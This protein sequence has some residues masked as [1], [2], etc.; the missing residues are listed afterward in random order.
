MSGHR[1]IVTVRESKSSVCSLSAGVHFAVRGHH[2]EGLGTPS[3]ADRLE[4]GQGLTEDRKLD[5][6]TLQTAKLVFVVKA[7][8]EHLRAVGLKNYKEMEIK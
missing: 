3:H 2:K 1:D 8:H 6:G 7:P 4:K 5:L